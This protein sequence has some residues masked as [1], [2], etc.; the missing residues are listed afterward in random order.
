MVQH[1][2]KLVVQKFYPEFIPLKFQ[3]E[4]NQHMIYHTINQDP[5]MTDVIT[6]YI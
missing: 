5:L 3:D 2:K 1:Q 4:V 6:E